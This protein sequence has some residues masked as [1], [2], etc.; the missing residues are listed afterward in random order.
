MRTVLSAAVIVLALAACSSTPTKEN[1]SAAQPAT[2]KAASAQPSATTGAT[3]PKA[4]QV[5]TIDPRKSLKDP[6]SILSKRSVY[7]DFDKYEIKPP[8]QPIIDAHGKFLASYGREKVRIEGNADERG[9]REYNLALGQKRAE[10]VK[11]AL[12]LSGASEA[13]IE[14]VSFGMEK[15][16]ALGHDEASW[17][18]NRRSDIRYGGEQ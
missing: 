10:V 3:S 5:A 4:T 2:G 13:R 8:Y 17:A 14:A 15:P 1:T 16:R 12:I 11:K 18:E 6:A 7:F 9:S